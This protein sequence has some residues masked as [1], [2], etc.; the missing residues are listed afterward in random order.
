VVGLITRVN[1]SAY[2][3]EVS[4]LAVW[5]QSNNLSLNVSEKILINLHTIA[6][7][8]KVKTGFLRNVCKFIKNKKQK[9]LIYISI[10]TLFPLIIL[11][12]FLQLDWSPPVVNSIDWT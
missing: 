7:N 3:E 2:R 1:E 9:Y 6:H 10:Q 5:C 8:D 12:M 4:D 11:E